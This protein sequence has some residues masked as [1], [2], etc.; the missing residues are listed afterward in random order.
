MKEQLI[1]FETAKLAKDRGFDEETVKGYYKHGDARLLLWIDSENYNE[2]KDFVCA[3]PTQSLLQKWLREMNSP[4]VLEVNFGCIDD[5]ESA[6]T[7]H[8]RE[9]VDEGVEGTRKKD[10]YDFWKNQDSFTHC[11]G[12][13]YSTYEKALEEGLQKSLKL[14]IN[15]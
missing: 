6:Y 3:A 13:W 9:Y 4:I 15:D 10:E 1:N 5:S 8:I 7:W 14:I 12:D 2:Q 11:G